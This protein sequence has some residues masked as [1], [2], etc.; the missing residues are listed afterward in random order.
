MVTPDLIELTGLFWLPAGLISERAV[1]ARAPKDRLA[2]VT[3]HMPEPSRPD[4]D[5]MTGDNSR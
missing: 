3:S 2:W 4:N 5:R 1:S